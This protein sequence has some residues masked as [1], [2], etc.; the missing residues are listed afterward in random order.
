MRKK[1]F[2]R[3]N[4]ATLTYERVYPTAKER[5]WGAVRHSISGITV[6]IIAYA[7]YTFY[8][9]TPSDKK[10]K[11]ELDVLTSQNKL[12]SKRLDK[13]LDVMG[14]IEERDDNLYRVIL[15]S[16]PTQ[17]K[18]QIT[19]LNESRYDEI[20]GLSNEKLIKSTAVKMDLLA[21]QIYLRS[22]S[23]DDVV[24]LLGKREERLLCTPAI[25]PILNRD[26]K[27]L[28]SGFGVRVDPIYH[29]AKMHSGMDFTARVG[30]PIYAT[31]NGR[32][33]QAGWDSG[34]GNC[35]LIN[36]GFGYQTK[37]A[38]MSKLKARAGQ[39][40]KRGEV[41]GYVGSTG[42]STAPHLHYEVHVNGRP[43]NPALYYFLD[44]SPRDYDRMIQL[45]ETR[46]QIFD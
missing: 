28:S 21:K 3:Y 20:N 7:L 34:Y 22:R 39:T 5:F 18:Q 13:A 2:Y 16:N 24:S 6:G 8:F 10:M 19:I 44:L 43:V 29:T 41:I 1:T 12:L 32:V 33:Q 11:R 25:Q 31:G 42:K 45:A 26:L 17:D 36:H 40:V 38:H 46:G 30:T 27:L 37:Y 4:P 14:N 23:F 9:D 35:V 15:Q